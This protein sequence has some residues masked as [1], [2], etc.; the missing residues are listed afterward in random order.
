MTASG[1]GQSRAD[2]SAFNSLFDHLSGVN[3]QGFRERL[4][5]KIRLW[6][7]DGFKAGTATGVGGGDQQQLLKPFRPA[8]DVHAVKQLQNGLGPQFQGSVNVGVPFAA[9]AG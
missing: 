8:P 4:T 7:V 9:E 1:F 5:Q 6:V 2:G 3:A